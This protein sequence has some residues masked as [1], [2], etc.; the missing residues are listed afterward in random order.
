MQAPNIETRGVWRLPWRGAHGERYLAV[1]DSL[2]NRI[3][4]TPVYEG[5]D[6]AALVEELWK[7]LDRED[8]PRQLLR[9][10]AD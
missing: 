7:L 6:V 4:T 3:Y 8:P 1:V 10:V 2:G 9:L 5:A